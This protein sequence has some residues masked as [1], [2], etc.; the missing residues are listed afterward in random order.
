MAVNRP[1]KN[2]LLLKG[3]YTWSKSMNMADEDGWVGVTWNGAS[4][5][6]RNFAL[7]GYDRTHVFQMGFVYELPFGK[8]G[9]GAMNYAIKDW[10]VNGIFA[11]FS[12]APF[13]ITADGTVVNMPGN[14]QTAQQ[15]GDYTVTGDIGNDGAWFDTTAFRQPQGV[16]SA[17]PAA[18]RSA[19]R[20]SGAWTSRSSAASASAATRS[21]SS[22]WRRST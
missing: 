3:A 16:R 11:A 4:Q 17:T 21:W 22:G 19:A 13:T 18:T 6:D 10:Q 8:D 5:Y 20:A 7:A 12:G 14:Q 15:V 9:S 1:F 2:G